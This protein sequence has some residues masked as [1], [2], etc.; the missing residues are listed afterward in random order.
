MKLLIVS[1]EVS[2]VPSVEQV[3]KAYKVQVVAVAKDIP[4]SR[5]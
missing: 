4:T 2:G 3:R 1:T 5:T